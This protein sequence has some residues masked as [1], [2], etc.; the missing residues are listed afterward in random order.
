MDW[1]LAVWTGFS[2][3]F[4]G[5]ILYLVYRFGF[6]NAVERGIKIKTWR[7]IV[8]LLGFLVSV[9]MFGTDYPDEGLLVGY[10]R[11]D[12]SRIVGVFAVLI[13]T[14]G[15]GYVDGICLRKGKPKPTSMEEPASK[16]AA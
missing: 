6:N 3:M 2:W 13:A 12:L 15:F 4:S 10:D 1:H 14:F 7:S 11:E 16:L 5:G 9:A 8:L